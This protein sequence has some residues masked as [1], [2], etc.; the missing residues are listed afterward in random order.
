MV[1][2]RR[3]SSGA[4]S[5]IAM[6]AGARVDKVKLVQCGGKEYLLLLRKEI[7]AVDV[8]LI[9]QDRIVGVNELKLVCID[10]VT[11]R[12]GELSDV[13]IVNEEYVAVNF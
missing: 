13:I 2:L 9:E 7:N 4:Y 6:V 8:K 5:S 11:G 12:E 3:L 10:Q 1:E